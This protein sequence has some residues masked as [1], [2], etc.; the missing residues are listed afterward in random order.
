VAS[1]GQAL[2]SGPTAL[3]RTDI[4]HLI[5]AAAEFLPDCSHYATCSLP[6]QFD[7]YVWFDETTA[8]TPRLT[9]WRPGAAESYPFGL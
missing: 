7:A 6:Q 3:R 1:L 4:P 9:E 2:G 8:V 5:R